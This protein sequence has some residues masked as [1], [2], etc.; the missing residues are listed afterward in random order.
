[1]NASEHRYSVID[2]LQALICEPTQE[3]EAAAETCFHG[4]VADIIG[5]ASGRLPLRVA[6]HAYRGSKSLL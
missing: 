1:M 2:N 5:T 4:K 6:F 3:G